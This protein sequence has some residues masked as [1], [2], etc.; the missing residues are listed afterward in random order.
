MIK[1]F[2]IIICFS[3]PNMLFCDDVNSDDLKEMQSACSIIN[4]K[5][6]DGPRCIKIQQKLVEARCKKGDPN[7]CKALQETNNNKKK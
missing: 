5:L 3:I 7:A 4:G 2:L 6:K 1:G